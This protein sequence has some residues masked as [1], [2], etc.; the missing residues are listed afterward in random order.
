MKLKELIHIASDAYPDGL[1]EEE[2]WDKKRDLPHRNPTG[3]D[4]LAYFIALELYETYDQN[5]TDEEQIST[6]IHALTK[7]Q[8][9]LVSINL[10]FS[11]ELEKRI[12]KKKHAVVA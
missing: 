11:H 3:G 8:E 6:A 4:T 12:G 1:I 7:A 9:E 10:S 5:A 2:Y